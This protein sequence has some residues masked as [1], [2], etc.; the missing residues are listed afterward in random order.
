MNK[1]ILFGLII[2]TIVG[3]SLF[4]FQYIKNNPSSYQMDGKIVESRDDSI[5]AAGTVTS[6]N[7]KADSNTRQ[8]KT[9]QFKITTQT[10]LHKTVYRVSK[11]IP[12]GKIFTPETIKMDGVVA[13]LKV[14]LGLRVRTKDNLFASDE[15]AAM[16]ISYEIIE[17][18]Q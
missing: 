6:L 1:K 2:L 3:I 7:P 17:Y 16:E 14:G 11:S 5:F 9:I 15:A 4:V 13:D 18:I 10:L 8:N 12:P